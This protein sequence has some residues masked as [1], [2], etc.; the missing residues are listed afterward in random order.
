M[1][2]EEIRKI[3][4]AQPFK[5]FTVRV[6]DGDALHVPHPDFLLIPPVG[7]TVIIVDQKGCMNLVDTAHITKLEFQ[8]VRTVKPP[9]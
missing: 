6:T 7:A 8:P 4:H 3:N 2:I 9:R 5:P 1:K